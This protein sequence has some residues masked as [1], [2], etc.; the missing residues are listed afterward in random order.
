M[1]FETVTRVVVPALAA[2]LAVI[3]ICLN[4]QADKS[5]RE[6]IRNYERIIEHLKGRQP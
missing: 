3:A 1:S 5:Y 6:A 2:V 4:R